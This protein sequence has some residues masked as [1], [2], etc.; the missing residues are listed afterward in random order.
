MAQRYERIFSIGENLYS[1]D[2]PIVVSAGVLLKDTKVERVV[3][4][5]KF[6]NLSKRIIRAIKVSI[7]AY[8]VTK[9]GLSG[10][11]DFQYL[12]LNVKI[13]EYFG[14]KT[15]IELPDLRTRQF[16]II[17]D[18]V[19]F[20]DGTTWAGKNVIWKP[21]DKAEK[22]NS[23][24]KDDELLKQYKIEFGKT[25]EYFYKESDNV[26]ICPCGQI[27]CMEEEKCSRCKLDK[28][29]IFNNTLE[30]MERKKAERLE[31][32]K[33][34]KQK[35]LEKERA[36]KEKEEKIKKE[37]QERIKRKVKL[38]AVILSTIILFT[39]V[40]VWV[41]NSYYIP[42]MEQEKVLK[43]ISSGKY[44]SARQVNNGKY[45]GLMINEIEKKA[46][47]H[48]EKNEIKKAKE[49]ILYLK[50][51]D[52]N[53]DK[54]LEI[55]YALAM[56]YLENEDFDE[57]K[58]QFEI[59]GQ[60]SDSE[61]Q[62]LETQYMKAKKYMSER[63]YNSAFWTLEEIRE[64]KDANELYKKSANYIAEEKYKEKIYNS[65]LRFY[66]VAENEIGIKKVKKKLKK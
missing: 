2:S 11:E 49:D 18:T 23:K 20:E 17:V 34:E 9:E 63:K 28:A 51:Y 33:E 43:Y 22:V 47:D 32:E 19:V 60:Y 25:A 41:M 55:R 54:V 52:R 38:T 15:A 61:V 66:Q 42:K 5:L 7:N 44:E 58:S 10:V 59:L 27:N 16:K 37:E 30:V 14:Q 13:G 56:K 8:D 31:R 45:I 24:F 26:W 39:I 3:A 53:H 29:K 35:K 65:A 6:Q 4:Q 12:D 57:A 46:K 21:L 64:Y 36:E 1:K 50:R 48:I 62:L 40:G